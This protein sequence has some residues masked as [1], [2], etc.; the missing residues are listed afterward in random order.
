MCCMRCRVSEIARR[1]NVTVASWEDGLYEADRSV[2]NRSRLTSDVLGY[3]WNNV[4]QY[5]RARRAYDLAN[6]GYKVGSLG[7]FRRVTLPQAHRC[8]LNINGTRIEQ[9]RIE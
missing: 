6:A 2:M 1:H 8:R 5:G 3:A 4:W 7:S 9:N